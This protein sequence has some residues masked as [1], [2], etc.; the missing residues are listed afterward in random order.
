MNIFEYAAQCEKMFEA[1]IMYERKT[2]FF[3]DLSIAE[4]FGVNAIEDTNKRV[5]KEWLNNIEYITEYS[6][7]LNHKIWQH[8]G[9]GKYD[10]AKVYDRL[11]K[12]CVDKIVEHYKDNDDAMSYYYDITD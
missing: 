3:S 11:W 6:M 7:C 8:H 1:N 10:L 5:L 9:A 12:D 4:C 2:T